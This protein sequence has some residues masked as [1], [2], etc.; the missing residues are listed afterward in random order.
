MPEKRE[1]T[2][3]KFFFQNE[4]IFVVC[5]TGLN[6]NFGISLPDNTSFPMI[7]IISL[8]LINSKSFRI[9]FIC[10]SFLCSVVKNG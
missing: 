10:H 9:E 4:Y 5:L 7:P 2:P 1:I 3:S 8:I 6:V